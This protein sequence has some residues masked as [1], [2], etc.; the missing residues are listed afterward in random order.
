M[1]VVDDGDEPFVMPCY[2][3]GV[4]CDGDSRLCP[5]CEKFYQAKVP[6]SMQSVDDCPPFVPTVETLR[7]EVLRRGTAPNGQVNRSTISLSRKSG[8]LMAEN[9]LIV[10]D[11]ETIRR[12]VSSTLTSVGYRCQQA[13]SGKEA[14]AI[15]KSDGE[16]APP[17]SES[18]RAMVST[19]QGAVGS[20]GK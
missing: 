15:L 6:T 18:S 17:C 3:C 13:S 19:W 2:R 10:N 8:R 7:V 11:E 1:Q 9:I 4:I 14:L 20:E 5:D 16:F 12:M